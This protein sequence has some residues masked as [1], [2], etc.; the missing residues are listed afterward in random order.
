MIGY[1]FQLSFSYRI[2][3]CTCKLIAPVAVKSVVIVASR[4]RMLYRYTKHA[5]FT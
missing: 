2:A 1:G 4:T 5:P 3:Q